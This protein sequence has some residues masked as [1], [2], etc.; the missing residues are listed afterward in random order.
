MFLF[1]GTVT[2]LI[3]LLMVGTGTAHV[4]DGGWQTGPLCQGNPPG[5]NG[6]SGSCYGATE[7]GTWYL[8]R[9]G[10]TLHVHW[11]LSSD[12][13]P[14]TDQFICSGLH[15]GEP[16]DV[17]GEERCKGNHDDR[18]ADGPDG[19]TDSANSWDATYTGS[20]T[21]F[22][23][24]ISTSADTHWS[25]AGT[26]QTPETTTTS[27]TTTTTTIGLTGGTS[28]AAGAGR[29][30]T[31]VTSRVRGGQLAAT[32]YETRA[33]GLMLIGLS[34]AIAGFLLKFGEEEL[35]VPLPLGHSND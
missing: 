21:Q 4:P 18:F 6:G 5:T 33:S 23:L 3:S 27:T 13:G 29:A 28:A 22:G 20:E 30:A 25:G 34:L 9:E 26:G 14:V 2:F 8:Q 11:H 12:P 24:H 32:G 19:S 31:G 15:K 35:D 1:V 7:T 16:E 10:N 17:H